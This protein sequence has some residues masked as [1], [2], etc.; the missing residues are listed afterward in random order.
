MAV[1]LKFEEGEDKQMS[2][3][4][5]KMVEGELLPVD[6]ENDVEPNAYEVFGLVLYQLI[7]ND[8]KGINQTIFSEMRNVLSK[9]DEQLHDTEEDTEEA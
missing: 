1:F 6:K 7:A 8:L 9:L 3:S 4:L 2:I 5:L